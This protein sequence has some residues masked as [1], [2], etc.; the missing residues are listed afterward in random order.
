[1]LSSFNL[2]KQK[3][4]KNIPVTVSWLFATIIVGIPIFGCIGNSLYGEEIISTSCKI[5]SFIHIATAIGF[6]A[7]AWLGGK[8]LVPSL[9]MFGLTYLLISGIG[10]MGMD[11]KIGEHWESVIQ[12]NLLN[13]VQ[14][15]LGVALSAIGML[16]K[17]YQPLLVT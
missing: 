3:T 12:L 17:K 10:F 5:Y 14:F 4:M 9:R 16:L 6:A 11:L 2:C 7:I 13:Y 8:L 1:L 15:S